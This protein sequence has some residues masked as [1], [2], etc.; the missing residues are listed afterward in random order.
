MP[1]MSGPEATLAIR[2]LGYQNPIIGV[3]GNAF[4]EAKISFLESGA[5]TVLVKP[6][7]KMTVTKILNSEFIHRAPLLFVVFL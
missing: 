3:T 5:T 6:I 4:E 2:D 7:N 1:H